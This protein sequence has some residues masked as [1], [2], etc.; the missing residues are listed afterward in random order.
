MSEPLSP[1]DATFLELED[2]DNTA[3][4]HIG[5]V[6]VFEPLP[7]GKTP[8]LAR[9]RR[10]LERRI[11]ALPRYRD[12]L[13]R[14]TTGG[15]RWPEWV[16]DEHFDIAMHVTRAALPR[17]GGERQLLEWAAD[18]W[19]HRLDRARPLWRVVLLE[20]LAGGRW[21]LVTKTHHCL[22]DGVGSVDA[23]TVLL[24]AEAKPGRWQKPRPP[25]TPQPARPNAL[26]RLA[27]VPVAAAGAAAG[28]V[29][30]PR[31]A[32]EGLDAARAM[33]ELLIRDELIPAPHASLNVQLSEHR[34]I[35]VAEVPLAEIKAIKRALGGTVNDVILSLVTSGLR[36]LMVARGETPPAA[37]LRAMVPVNVRDAAEHLEL[38]NRITSLFVHLPVS[39]AEPR[40][41]YRRVRAETMRL[42]AAHQARGGQ[43]LVDLAGLAPPALHSVVAQAL[44]ATRLFNVTVTN[45]PGSPTTLYAFGAPLR[46]VIPL[47]PLAA[48]HSIAVAALSYDGTVF[49][50][51]HADRDAAPDAELV[52]AGIEAEVAALAEVAEAAAEAAAREAARAR[53]TAAP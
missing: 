47:V 46:R 1:L 41:R 9:V 37:G 27:G 33:L 22:V 28:V 7:G 11:E 18:F 21:A 6:L 16:P 42:K 19:S 35:A 32:A 29:R 53:E 23:G 43:L 40:A 10:H 2:A 51:V 15:L 30:H 38:G 50:C 52:A 12:K 17:P 13:S 31:R 44:F 36:D 25:V 24:D 39:V 45:V 14:R 4:M 49:F 3:H 48:E 20:G 34:R 8:T 26:G 5:G